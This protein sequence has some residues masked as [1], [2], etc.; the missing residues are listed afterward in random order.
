M[1]SDV[2]KVFDVMG[3]F[4]PAIIKMKILLQ[5]LWEIKLDWD[6]PI[7]EHIYQDWFQWRSELPLLMTVRIPRCYSPSKETI[8]STQLHGFSDASEEAYAGVVYL[9]IEYST[10]RVHTS[11]VISKTKVSPIKRL[12]IPRL[13]LCG[14]Q[15]L[16]RL[17]QRTMKILKIPVRSVFAWTDSTVVLGW[18]SGNP[19]RFKTFVGNRVSLI[20]DQLPPERWRH[21]PGP[22]NPADCASRGLFPSQL[23]QHELWWDGPPWLK[24]ESS[25]WPDQLNLSSTTVPEEERNVCHLATATTAQLIIPFDRFSYIFTKLKRIT[26]WVLRFVKNARPSSTS[27][28]CPHL[29]VT[30]LISA[31]NYWISI[32]QGE[33]FAEEIELLKTGLPLP[34]NNRFL[35]LRPFLDQSLALLRV[36]GRMS[37]SKLAYSKMHPV[38]LHGSHPLT[39]LIVRGEHIRLMHAGPTLLMSS[40]SRQ[41]HITGLP[42]MVRSFSRQCITCRRHTVKPTSQLLGQLLIDPSSQGLELTM[43]DPSRSNMDMSRSRPF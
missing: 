15:T 11:L 20:I 25:M 6:D 12:S 43:Q 37:H 4:S 7:P 19:R 14:A 1:V 24:S 31:E 41:Y 26:A 9:R 39:R 22:E 36:G 10:K 34:K 40:L 3:W 32:V 27:E 13:E 38:I 2:A 16:T 5:H 29:T 33:C 30:E 21:I 35:P 42:K 23:K 18:L 17:L 8:V 28:S